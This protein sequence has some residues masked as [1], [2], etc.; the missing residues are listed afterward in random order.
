M[1]DDLIKRLQ[2]GPGSRELSDEVLREFGWQTSRR[3]GCTF[4][5][6]PDS[7]DPVW[8]VWNITNMQPDPSRNAQDALDVVVPD[9]WRVA[10]I[11]TSAHKKDGLIWFVA[12]ARGYHSDDNYACVQSDGCPDFPA[13]LCIAG[14]LAKEKVDER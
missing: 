14:L 12:L 4:W 7:N 6:G 1:T 3:D 13:A 8:G 5:R 2:A 9:G 10:Q 11:W